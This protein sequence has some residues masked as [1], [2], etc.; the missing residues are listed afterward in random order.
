MLS[1]TWTAAALA[2]LV[3]FCDH[4]VHRASLK[5]GKKSIAFVHDL[6]RIIG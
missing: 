2:K 4:R 1:K 3:G 5:G 6:Y